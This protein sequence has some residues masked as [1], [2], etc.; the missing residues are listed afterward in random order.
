M[1][2]RGTDRVPQ[3][4]GLGR[5]QGLDVHGHDLVAPQGVFSRR[6][7]QE[8]EAVLRLGDQADAGVVGVEAPLQFGLGGGDFDLCLC[9]RS[10]HA[11]GHAELLARPFDAVGE[12]VD[13]LAR[14]DQ[15]PISLLD[16]HDHV[17]VA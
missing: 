1:L 16:A 8:F 3:V 9:A 10:H 4:A 2:E 15:S 14:G 13:G 11:F 7:H 12:H 6:G 5:L 17:D